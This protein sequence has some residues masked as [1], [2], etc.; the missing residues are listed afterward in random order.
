[1]EEREVRREEMERQG[2][3]FH[4]VNIST[5]NTSVFEKTSPSYMYLQFACKN[6]QLNCER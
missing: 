3:T 6:R 1:M 2:R 5:I 4:K